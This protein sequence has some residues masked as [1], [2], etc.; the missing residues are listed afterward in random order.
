MHALLPADDL[1]LAVS[2]TPEFWRRYT[3]ARFFITGGT[4]FVGRW[5]VQAIQHANNTRQARMELLVLT[6][7]PQRARSNQA[8]VFDRSDTRLVAGNVSDPLP[9]LGAFDL[10]IHAATDVGAALRPAGPLEVYD[11]IVTGTRRVLEAAV[12]ADARRFLLTSSGAIYGTQ[13]PELERV[14]E[15]YSGAPSTLQPGAAYGNGKRAAEWLVA[16]T[17]LSESTLCA[18]SARIFTLLGPGLPRNAGFAAGNFIDDALAGR[19]IRIEGDG[20]PLRSYLYMAD[21]AAWL[22]RILE[23]GISGDAYNVGSED[24]ISIGDL[25]LA[26][27][28]AAG[29]DIAV[30]VARPSAP[31]GQRVARY[32]PDTAKARRELGLT[33]STPLAS[34]I[35]KTIAWSR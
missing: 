15:S 5:L 18:C 21:C 14:P 33:E 29:G 13:P 34:G 11:T 32:V 35:A 19:N 17:Q 12:A 9:R 24:A 25:A 3:G 28:A 16:A 10:C 27:A 8:E 23:A 30:D 1:D 20:L 6:R 7:D 2:L 4:G 31:P 26:V 22:L